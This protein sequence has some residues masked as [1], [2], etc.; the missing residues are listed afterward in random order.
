MFSTRFRSS[1]WVLHFLRRIY[2]TRNTLPFFIYFYPVVE[3][4]RGFVSTGRH[5]NP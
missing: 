5:E 2:V 1:A 4:P 3:W